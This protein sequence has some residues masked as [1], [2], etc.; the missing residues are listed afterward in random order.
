MISTNDYGVKLEMY[1]A[2]EI[3]NPIKEDELLNYS[4]TEYFKKYNLLDDF[5]LI[6]ARVR[7]DGVIYLHK[8]VEERNR[9]QK[10]MRNIFNYFNVFSRKRKS[11]KN[12][13]DLI[14]KEIDRVNI[15]FDSIEKVYEDSVD[16]VTSLNNKLTIINMIP[17]KKWSQFE[18]LYMALNDISKFKSK[19]DIELYY[20]SLEDKYAMEYLADL[21][22]DA[23]YYE[24]DYDGAEFAGQSE[25]ESYREEIREEHKVQ[26]ERNYIMLQ[27][28]EKMQKEHNNFVRPLINSGLTL[29]EIYAFMFTGELTS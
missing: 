25:L 8:L 3:G 10:N 18:G 15:E 16:L 26:I 13:L 1:R 19:E 2:F 9:L 4:L 12:M 17:S 20:E 7:Y 21:E 11:I 14:N 5:H 23:T 22:S 27:N 6:Y 29:E 24:V 28:K